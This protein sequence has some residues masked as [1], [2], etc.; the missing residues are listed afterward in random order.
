MDLKRKSLQMLSGFKRGDNK[1]VL[2]I[3]LLQDSLAYDITGLSVRANFRRPDSAIYFQGAGAGV[4]II[5]A[6]QGEIK[7][8]V[9]SEAL[10]IMGE[11]QA[12][13]S[14]FD[15]DENKISSGTFKMLVEDAMY[16]E[17]ALESRQ[18][19]DLI[20]NIIASEQARIDAEV[21]R[22]QDELERL[23]NEEER[24]NNESER[25][26]SEDV[27]TSNEAV[28]V[29]KETE[30]Q[31]NENVRKANETARVEEFS[32][33]TDAFA[34][35]VQYETFV[36]QEVIVDK[37]INEDVNRL[38]EQLNDIV[39]KTDNFSGSPK[40]T[41]A[42]L[43]ALQTAFPTGTTGIYLVTADGGWYY[44]NGSAWTKGGTYQATSLSSR[45][46][47]STKIQ[48]KAVIA[49]K[50]DFIIKSVNLFNKN[51]SSIVLNKYLNSTG[52]L[53]DAT[54][55]FITGK[56]PVKPGAKYSITR[57]SSVGDT[58]C[59]CYYDDNDQ[60]IANV[61]GVTQSGNV[62]RIV[63][64][65]QN[66]N[67]AYMKLNNHTGNTSFMIVAEGETYPSY[68]EYYRYLDETY[69]LNEKQKS[70][71]TS[72]ATTVAAQQPIPA[73]IQANVLYSKTALWNGDSICA[74]YGYAGG[75]AG[76]ITANNALTSTNYGVGGGTIAYYS[77]DRHCISRNIPNMSDTAD[78]IILQGGINDCALNVPLGDFVF[79]GNTSDWTGQFDDTTFC[80]AFEKMIQQAILK[81]K[82]KKIGFIIT[83]KVHGQILGFNNYRKKIIG[84][85]EKWSLPYL[86]LYAMSGLNGMF[87]EI[88]SLY[89]KTAG[90]Y[91]HVNEEGY[92]QFLVP[93]IEA[94]MKTL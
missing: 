22:T 68:V 5:N 78:Y 71:V 7:V 94:W 31:N 2:Y 86:D 75:Y 88:N 55:L 3:K 44:W 79:A 24:Q 58:T 83:Y 10:D 47:T 56:I 11:L 49:D 26:T 9:L 16:S 77:S 45:V 69:K 48:E 52:G 15:A 42:T 14:I 33:M 76:I 73:N 12:D 62:Y 66:D 18:G 20:Q 29:T 53:V 89:F 39:S 6:A 28:R 17:Y 81:W 82:G 92:R 41:Y 32:N 19:G 60:F 40:G 87:P 59:G 51:D 27:R 8:T 72:I 84:M 46:V 38:S 23:T 35:T 50:V 80:G 4:D 85:C 74:G 1:D 91:Y 57:T 64:V 25:V 93:K 36:D 65:P 37:K 30:R 54:N 21:L 70:E 13:I 63:T 43:T 67:I 61:T 90:D 34:E